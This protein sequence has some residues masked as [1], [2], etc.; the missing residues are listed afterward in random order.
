MPFRVFRVVS[1]VLW[2][3]RFRDEEAQSMAS[4]IGAR[5][6]TARRRVGIKGEHLVGY[7]FISPLL[8][9]FAVYH[10]YPIVRS[11]WMSFTDFKYLQPQGTHFVGLANYQEAVQSDYVI[12]GILLGIEYLLIYVP[13][14]MVLALI[15][16][17]ALDRVSSHFLA[18]AYRTI[19][20]LPVVMPGAV[21]YVLWKWMYIPSFG[22]INYVLVDTLHLFSTRPQWL[23]SP[24]WALASVAFMEIWR[25]LGYNVLLL[26]VGLGSINRELYEAARIDGASELQL[27]WHVTLPL[28]KPIF[29][30][31]MVLK[32]SVFAVV[33][34]MLI[35]PGVGESTWTW[36]WYAYDQAF[37]EGNLRMGY[38]AAIGYVGALIMSVF[39]YFQ[40]RLFRHERA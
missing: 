10:L 39:V 32:M 29:L 16:A 3:K 2:S 28:L 11:F 20:Y 33:E 34:P 14:A 25:F 37:L 1:R 23:A 40:Y 26:L 12:H 19:Y 35:A 24:D 30:V 13:L 7:A 4:L 36:A 9:L 5:P 22:L 6:V 21:V 31:M 38:A 27:V 15:I 18:G 17:L 8:A